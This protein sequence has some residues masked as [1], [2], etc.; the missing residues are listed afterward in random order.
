MKMKDIVKEGTLDDLGLRGHGD[1]L[2]NDEKDIGKGFTNDPIFD[3]LG[4]ILDTR[5]GDDPISSVKTDDGKELPVSPR[6]AV[7]LRRLLTA[8]GMKPQMKLRFTKDIQMSNNLHD[9]LDVHPDKMSQVFMK[10]YM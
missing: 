2:D 8:E 9:F 4:Q 3:Q 7:N 10:K 6:Q 1:E 5:T